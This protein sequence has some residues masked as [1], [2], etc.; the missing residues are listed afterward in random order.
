MR[1]TVG[2]LVLVA[3]L[4]LVA[5][6]LVHSRESEIAYNPD[7]LVRLHVIANS[8]LEAD[9]Q[10]KYEVRDII[11]EELEGDFGQ[12]RSVAEAETMIN[13]RLPAIQQVA[14]SYLKEK[15]KEVPVRVEYGTFPF[16]VKAYGSLILPAGEY[17]A[18]RVVLGSGQG[19]NWWCVVFPPLCF[20][21]ITQS[22]PDE[23]SVEEVLR[24]LRSD[25]DNSA[26]AKPLLKFK[27][28][29][30]LQNR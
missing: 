3:L 23:A 22:Q 13:S 4:L 28:L 11:L 14:E 24:S 10:L 17:K 5:G 25:G 9:Q 15:G 12:S 16:P 30:L 21:D 29:E 26:T 20:V 6:Q 19:A 8:D 18:I 2:G 1:K 27:T 7:N